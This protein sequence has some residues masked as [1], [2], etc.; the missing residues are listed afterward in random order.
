MRG[1]VFVVIGSSGCHRLFSEALGLSSNFGCIHG[2]PSLSFKWIAVIMHNHMANDELCVH[3][4]AAG[5]VL[6]VHFGCCF[7]FHCRAW[8]VLSVRALF[9]HVQNQLLLFVM[10]M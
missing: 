2:V 1:I 10:L 6:L 3:L 4:C 7:G 5:F 9:I 8:I